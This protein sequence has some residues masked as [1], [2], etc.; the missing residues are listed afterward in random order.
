MVK[1]RIA[2]ATLES[3]SAP[4]YPLHLLSSSPD[5]SPPRC[6]RRAPHPA[7]A[8]HRKGGRSRRTH[9]ADLDH[10]VASLLCFAP[11]LL[12]L[13]GFGAAVV[14]ETSN[15]VVPT[16]R[17]EPARPIL[18]LWKIKAGIGLEHKSA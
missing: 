10:V 11:T 18:S 6:P 3:S 1:K 17:S 12:S 2:P 14:R 4:S 7:V 5:P 16:A 15:T 13:V 8:T 9:C